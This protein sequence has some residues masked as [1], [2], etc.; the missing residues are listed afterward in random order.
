MMKT[1]VLKLLEDL[2]LVQGAWLSLLI[3]HFFIA[4]INLLVN[5]YYKYNTKIKK[6]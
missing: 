5:A 2:I 4:L 1:L 6:I 3:S